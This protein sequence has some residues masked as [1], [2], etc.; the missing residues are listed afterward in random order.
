M[1]KTIEY[2]GQQEKEARDKLD[3]AVN[4]KTV[5]ADFPNAVLTSHGPKSE[6]KYTVSMHVETLDTLRKLVDKFPPLWAN[7][8]VDT[9]YQFCTT[10]YMEQSGKHPPEN[11]NCVERTSLRIVADKRISS[12]DW[13]AN[14]AGVRIKFKADD[15]HGIK[16]PKVHEEVER[17]YN[18]K[19]I[20]EYLCL[21]PS[22]PSAYRKQIAGSYFYLTYDSVEN[23]FIDL[24]SM[25]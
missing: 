5:M 12:V 10:D 22:L 21:E 14:F 9:F 2:L 7:E 17:G 16:M 25:N 20:R 4:L 3:L 24:A 1:D 18:S 6:H 23:L 11:V 19:V 15:R 13:I 8:W